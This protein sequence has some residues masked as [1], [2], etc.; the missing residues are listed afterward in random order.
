MTNVRRLAMIV[1]HLF[2]RESVDIV[3]KANLDI[4]ESIKKNNLRLWMVADVMGMQDSNFTKMLR[5]T[6][7]PEKKAEVLAAIESLKRE[8]N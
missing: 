4:Y 6:L 8:V 2:N 5:K 7:S 3:K 1:L